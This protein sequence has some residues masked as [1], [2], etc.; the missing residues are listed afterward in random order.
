MALHVLLPL[1]L[2]FLAASA[3]VW[4]TPRVARALRDPDADGAVL[5]LA[6][7]ARWAIAG[8]ALALTAA[9]LFARSKGLT[10]LGV[11]FLCEELYETT[12]IISALRWGR[13]RGVV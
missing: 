6:H 13:A 9:G 12:V 8:V 3:L 1:L 11:V 5:E 10:L 2:S 4:G 7:G